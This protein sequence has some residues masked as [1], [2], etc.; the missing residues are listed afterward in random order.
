MIDYTLDEINSVLHV[1]PMGPLEGDDFEQLS[2]T[3]DPF[4]ERTGRLRGLLVET[5]DFPGWTDLAA[6][7]RHFR[8]VR[9]HHRQIEKVAFVTESPMGKIAEQLASHFV[10][11][12]IRR[13]PFSELAEAKAW[14]IGTRDQRIRSGT[15]G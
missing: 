11:A 3:V 13:F 4:I 6:V 2:R 8:F 1:R 12:T 9:E 7:A 10:A 14:V 15:G 5:A